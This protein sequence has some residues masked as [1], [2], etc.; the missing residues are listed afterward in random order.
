[1][2]YSDGLGESEKFDVKLNGAEDN[3]I[4]CDTLVNTDGLS[5]D[6]TVGAED[7][8]INGGEVE[9]FRRTR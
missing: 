6:T 7:N 3:A 4:D 2:K 1:M 5:L 8:A 9:I